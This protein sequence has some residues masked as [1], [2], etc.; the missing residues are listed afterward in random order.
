VPTALAKLIM[1]RNGRTMATKNSHITGPNSANAPPRC[2][3]EREQVRYI[4]NLNSNPSLAFYATRDN[5]L[6]VI[7]C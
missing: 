7:G 3:L 2:R 5:L 1:S 6:K 4:F